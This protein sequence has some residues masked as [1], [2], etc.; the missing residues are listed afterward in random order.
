MR[1]V[2]RAEA[3]GFK[4]E[5]GALILLV[6]VIV[7]AVFAFGLPT[8]VQR[9]YA[10]A[11]CQVS[12]DEDCEELE[13]GTADPDASASPSPNGTDGSDGATA[14]PSASPSA[15]P[16]ADDEDWVNPADALLAEYDP[17]AAEEY[18]N[19]QSDLEEAQSDLDEAGYDDV[20]DELLNLV[21]DIIGYNDARDCITKGDIMA[22]LW[23][24]VGFTPWGKGAKLAKNSAK[25]VKLWNRFRKA[26]KAKEAAEKAVS[27]AQAKLD[28]LVSK[29]T[30]S[31]KL[32]SFLPCT[33]VLMADGTTKAISLVEV[34]DLVMAAD[35][36]T[37]ERS[38][39]P[40]TAV[41][42]S[43]G[44]KELVSLGF[45]D[46]TGITGA[47]G[48]TATGG[49]PFWVEDEQAWKEA[50]DLDLG[51]EVIGPDGGVSRVTAAGTERRAQQVNNL[52]VAN[53]HTYYVWTG[54]GAAL[55]H[56]CKLKE[57]NGPGRPFQTPKGLIFRDRTYKEGDQHALQH[58]LE[59]SSD[60]SPKAIERM[61]NGQPHTKFK[62]DGNALQTLN[63]AWGKRKKKD[64]QKSTNNGRTTFWIP[65]DNTIGDDGE[66][67][68]KIVVE[69]GNEVV[70]AYPVKNKGD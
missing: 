19:A 17:V 34:G 46:G 44:D 50:R 10:S 35:P 49:H 14:G 2:W 23:T 58:V 37:G 61:K 3:G 43:Y 9:F 29:V 28:D 39:Q 30:S 6:A 8:D 22:C 64:V 48:I 24:V 26:K 20:R 42:G 4:V 40:V 11:I 15:S 13:G 69:K 7:T 57:L 51:D 59:H 32:S 16:G 38:P 31:C 27:T 54:S 68:V 5:Y 62:Q 12:G 41:I 52:S 65:M 21:G 66:K 1:W 18:A 47:G 53:F 63:D 55:V 33:E 67:I 60:S 56:N 25:I 70:T 45:H 36:V